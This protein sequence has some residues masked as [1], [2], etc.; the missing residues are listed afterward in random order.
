MVLHHPLA[1]LESGAQLVYVTPLNLKGKTQ[2]VWG[3]GVLTSPF[4]LQGR[5]QDDDGVFWH[6][7]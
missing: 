2:A 6:T 7:P 5:S 1:C 3:L 4:V